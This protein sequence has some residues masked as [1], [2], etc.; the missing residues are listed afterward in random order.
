ML[1]VQWGRRF[2]VGGAVGSSL[3][4]QKV[5]GLWLDHE[6]ATASND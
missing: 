2:N 6:E 4:S 1:S 5:S 3:C